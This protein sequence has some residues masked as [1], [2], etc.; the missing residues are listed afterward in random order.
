MCVLNARVFLCVREMRAPLYRTG[1]FQQVN[2]K[3]LIS[4]KSISYMRSTHSTTYTTIRKTF[5]KLIFQ[6]HKSSWKCYYGCYKPFK[7]LYNV[8]E[9]SNRP[10]KSIFFFIWFVYAASYLLCVCIYT[11]SGIMYFTTLCI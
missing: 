8:H 11:Y 4:V 7:K 5:W 3:P 1:T 2:I 10:L 6:S 9:C